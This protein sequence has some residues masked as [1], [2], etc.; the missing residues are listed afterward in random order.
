MEVRHSLKYNNILL[1]GLERMY[2]NMYK[3]YNIQVAI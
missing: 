1:K 2:K 3:G